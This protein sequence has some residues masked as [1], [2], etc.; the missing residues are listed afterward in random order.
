MVLTRP[1][2]PE[3]PG[4]GGPRGYHPWVSAS[5]HPP[6]DDPAAGTRPP[7]PGLLPPGFADRRP[8]HRWVQVGLFVLV[9]INGLDGARV[10]LRGPGLGF[11]DQD[12]ELLL[13]AV[14]ACTIVVLALRP[15]W[16]W[17]PLAA[18]LALLLPLENPGSYVVL[19]PLLLAFAAYAAAL[20]GLGLALAAVLVWQVAWSAGFSAVGPRFLWS[21]VPLTLVLTLPG[22]V[23]RSLSAQRERDRAELA[24]AEESTGRALEQQ[25]LELARELHDIIAHDLTVI[26]MQAR[27]GAYAE[28]PAVM[29]ETLGVVGDSS[30]AALRDLRRLLQVMRSGQDEGPAGEVEGAV[31]ADPRSDLEDVAEALAEVGVP[32]RTRCEGSLA[33]IPDSV[34]PTVRRVLREAATNVMKHAPGT[35]S[36]VLSVVV[37]G[38]DVHVEV[39]NTAGERTGP[40]FPA[41]GFGL[42]GLRERVHLLGGRLS[43]GP[44][45]EGWRVRASIPLTAAAV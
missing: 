36:C 34:R 6:H 30:R 2:R 40:R 25:R 35:T 45:A 9:G 44:T 3:G 4:P 20:P 13:L 28:D 42:T 33:R 11:G 12:Y 5:P 18:L 32:V 14:E 17:V 29:R 10:V 43:A 16:T 15:S 26:A 19:V 1:L 38:T 39:G 41:S 22:L 37:D 31:A 24:A 23:L 27:S 21:Y 8:F 7:G